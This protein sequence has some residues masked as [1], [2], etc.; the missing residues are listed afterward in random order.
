[1]TQSKSQIMTQTI[2]TTITD[3]PLSK[4][5]HGKANVRKTNS[6]SLEPLIAS[7]RAH[8]LIQNL[9]VR[10]ILNK[11]GHATGRYSVVAGNR[12]LSALQALA[13]IP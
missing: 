6:G 1:M 2:T 13:E 11:K 8:G 10:P 7:L 5:T 3:L 9:T 12:R 4:L